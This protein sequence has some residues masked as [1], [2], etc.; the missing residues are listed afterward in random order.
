MIELN[1]TN[2]IYINF[3]ELKE[4]NHIE[5]AE[6]WIET[7]KNVYDSI[8][9][10]KRASF[11]EEKIFWLDF[12][13]KLDYINTKK[14]S[15]DFNALKNKLETKNKIVLS[16]TLSSYLTVDKHK[17]L[18]K[19]LI[20]FFNKLDFDKKCNLN[21][22]VK[23]TLAN[24]SILNKNH[25]KIVEKI[26]KMYYFV[27]CVD[28]I[29]EMKKY[30]K[31]DNKCIAELLN[32]KTE[33]I[34][35]DNLFIDFFTNIE[36]LYK[37]VTFNNA[38]KEVNRYDNEQKYNQL[39]TFDCVAD[40]KNGCCNDVKQ[41]NNQHNSDCNFFNT[42]QD[43]D[44]S[45][46]EQFVN[47]CIMYIIDCDTNI[48]TLNDE[49]YNITNNEI[50][51]A[52]ITNALNE[53]YNAIHKQII[54]QYI[55]KYSETNIQNHYRFLPLQSYE[56]FSNATY[57]K[58]CKLVDLLTDKVNTIFLHH[59]KNNLL[60][61][62][63]IEIQNDLQCINDLENVHSYKY[64]QEFVEQK[65]KDIQKTEH[66]KY[67][68]NLDKV[69][70]IVQ[71]KKIVLQPDD[72]TYNEDLKHAI[73]IFNYY[74][75]NHS[76][77]ECLQITDAAQKLKKIMYCKWKYIM[78]SKKVNDFVLQCNKID[79]TYVK[80]TNLCNKVVNAMIKHYTTM[81]KIENKVEMRIDGK[82]VNDNNC[83]VEGNTEGSIKS[84]IENKVEN[85][86]EC[87]I[88]SNTEKFEESNTEDNIDS[89]IEYKIDTNSTDSNSEKQSH[90]TTSFYV[91]N[92]HRNVLLYEYNYSYTININA[93]TFDIEFVLSNT[94]STAKNNEE[95]LKVYTK[96][97]KRIT[98][99]LYE[100][101]HDIIRKGCVCN[102]NVTIRNNYCIFEPDLQKYI[103]YISNVFVVHDNSRNATK[104]VESLY[105]CLTK[106]FY[107]LK[108]KICKQKKMIKDLVNQKIEMKTVDDLQDVCIFLYKTLQLYNTSN[109]I[110]ET[111][112]NNEVNV[113]NFKVKHETY[114][115]VFKNVVVTFLVG[116]INLFTSK[117]D[118]Y[119]TFVKNLLEKDYKAI[120][121]ELLIVS[122]F[123]REEIRELIYY[124]EIVDTENGF[125][126]SDNTG[127]GNNTR[128][129]N[130]T[131]GGNNTRAGNNTWGGN[132]NL[133][134]N[135]SGNDILGGKT[136]KN[137]LQNLLYLSKF[138]YTKKINEKFE[139]KLESEIKRIENRKRIEKKICDYKN[140]IAF[141]KGCVCDYK[142]LRKINENNIDGK[143]LGGNV[144]D[145]S[146][147]DGNVIIGE[148]VIGENVIYN[149]VLGE[150]LI[151][152]N[153]IG[154]NVIRE[155]MNGNV[156][157]ENMNG[158]NM[159]GEK[160][161]DTKNSNI[162]RND[163]NIK[164]DRYNTLVGYLD[165]A[166][167]ELKILNK[168]ILFMIKKQTKLI[169]M[170]LK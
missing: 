115:S 20:A 151:D 124:I 156:I 79:R 36:F 161:P 60:Q 108:N 123:R 39:D 23:A 62:Y 29:N 100:Y 80:N 86:I 77:D 8:N 25:N 19:N 95:I 2:T 35:H 140:F 159:I 68:E 111:I 45:S 61:K 116:I 114:N 82:N 144:I 57:E 167:C 70:I 170:N 73:Y 163:K 76:N 109:E 119:D 16:T 18:A 104:N 75:V 134:C 143:I 162:I 110:V 97:Y 81:T 10:A 78:N 150:N 102:I 67:N 50:D 118:T 148:N 27:Y 22:F 56:M 52:N 101:L 125:V 149:N 3:C 42:K 65:I 128:A 130:N 139:K 40:I 44:I 135:L 92:S 28:V 43:S 91:T 4:D 127:G 88:E 84:N 145:G 13:K 71:N 122:L 154:E 155:N 157:C 90:N 121:V 66:E 48:K 129:G 63:L 55:T 51:N 46:I 133:D 24:F 33:M 117:Q 136:Y 131:R 138:E 30:I 160:L 7:L 153:V 1:K 93:E 94:F 21:D 105:E 106:D 14:E 89:S 98:K 15:N 120:Y 137:A 5:C 164:R 83:K 158:N 69:A 58:R 168:F 132:I 12:D 103:K 152:D 112:L 9:H 32:Y 17:K 49:Y 87:N 113:F 6:Q 34:K 146:I 72:C 37:V 96:Q 38:V 74:L 64:L 85:N 126:E 59:N 107:K 141:M 11:E 99:M 169:V 54:N 142:I 147:I 41:E 26:A 47:K 165:S 31:N 166:E 53:E